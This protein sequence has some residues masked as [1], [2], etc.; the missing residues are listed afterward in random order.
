M[1]TSNSAKKR[2]RTSLNAAA[3]NKAVR[4][5]IITARKAVMKAQDDGDANTIKQSVSVYFSLLDKAVKHGVIKP[6]T[7]ARRKSRVT[8]KPVASAK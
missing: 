3:S 1:P 2:V 7:A 6:N 8:K 4:T 5:E